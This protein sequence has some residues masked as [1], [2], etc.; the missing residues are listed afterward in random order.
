MCKM[1]KYIVVFV[2]DF[3]VLIISLVWKGWGIDYWMIIFFSIKVLGW[4]ERYLWS[5]Y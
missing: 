3:G 2:F 4:V 5:E 1:C